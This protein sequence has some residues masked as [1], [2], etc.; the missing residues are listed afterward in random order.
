M[1]NSAL[2][3][4]IAKYLPSA[5]FMGLEMREYNGRQLTLWAPLAPN[6]NDKHTAFGGSLY[7]ASVLACWG[8]VYMRCVD[9]GL[10]PDI[11]VAKAE[12]EYIK[13]VVG[14]ILSRSLVIDENRWSH[15]FAR[16]EERGRAKID[17][18]AE[19]SVDG[20]VA[21]RFSGL[22]AIVGVK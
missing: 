18:A 4:F 3:A 9:Y 19:I 11:V 22:Y 10:D 15:F 12:I 7:C 14:D 16:Y 2:D 1:A 21:V 17:L 6:V 13:P 5:R 20:E 8:M